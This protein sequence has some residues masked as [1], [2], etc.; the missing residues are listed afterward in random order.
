[1]AGVLQG[2][3][4]NASDNVLVTLAPNMVRERI[5]WIDFSKALSSSCIDKRKFAKK[6]S[7]ERQLWSQMFK[8]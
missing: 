4:E 1:M 6:A 5:V 2:D 7:I 3:V 8:E